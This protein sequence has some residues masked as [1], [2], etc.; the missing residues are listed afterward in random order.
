MD[1]L[2]RSKWFSTLDVK[3]G[4]WQ[5]ALHPTTKRNNISTGQGLRLFNVL[6]FDPF[7]TPATFDRLMESVLQSLSFDD[8]LVYLDVLIV[9]GWTFTEQLDNLRKVRFSGAYLKLNPEKYQLFHKEVRY[10]GRVLSN[11]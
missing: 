6:A 3:S 11:R 1:T 8:C 7:R 4:F 10:I 9:V 5:V 2:A